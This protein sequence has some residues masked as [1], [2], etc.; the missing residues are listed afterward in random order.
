[1]TVLFVQ[2]PGLRTLYSQD[3][4]VT[5]VT[6]SSSS[7][8]LPIDHVSKCLLALVACFLDSIPNVPAFF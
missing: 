8:L 2:L 7:E 3:V 5:S 4:F 6:F 1:M